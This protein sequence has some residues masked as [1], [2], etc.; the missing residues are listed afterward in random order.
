MSNLNY[1]TD[2]WGEIKGGLHIMG[3]GTAARLGRE[4]AQM[5]VSDAR[6]LEGPRVDVAS[7][8]MPALRGTDYGRQVWDADNG[9]HSWWPEL[10]NAHVWQVF[11]DV[12]E[13]TLEAAGVYMGTDEF[14]PD[15]LHVVDTHRWEYGQLSDGDEDWVKIDFAAE[16][17]AE[18]E[19]QG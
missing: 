10:E 18:K 8:Y 1:S 3:L 9:T 13:E 4:L 6:N 12:I 5:L 16:E 15:R 7:G 2:W 14:D 17:A 19:R 11:V